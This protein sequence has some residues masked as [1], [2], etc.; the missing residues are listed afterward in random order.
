MTLTYKE[1]R[2]A[3]R[4]KERDNDEAKF[5]DYE[6]KEAVNEAI[7]YLSNS[8]ADTNADFN[9][10]NMCYGD[11]LPPGLLLHEGVPLPDDFLAI[12]SIKDNPVSERAMIPCSSAS[13]PKPWEYKVVGNRLYAGS[14]IVFVT[15]KTS[16][17]E[18]EDDDSDIDLPY[19]I[20]DNFVTL[21]RRILTG[22]EGDIMR[23][24]Q[25]N[26]V[27]ALLPKR[28]YRNAKIKMP[29]RIGW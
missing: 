11:G 17:S 2:R 29:F 25:E 28:R 1:I 23:E 19:F 14:P 4:F 24:A 3:V 13:V 16:I 18:V 22:S 27:N 26:A 8:L 5:S 21:V 10:K 6:I 9:E 20:K 15:Y 12:V 7:R